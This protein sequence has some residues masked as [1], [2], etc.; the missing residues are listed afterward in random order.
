MSVTYKATAL[1]GIVNIPVGGY[2]EH[3][4]LNIYGNNDYLPLVVNGAL[5]H[6]SIKSIVFILVR[7]F[8]H[9]N[10]IKYFW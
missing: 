2:N 8:N 4:L 6:A 9:T 3:I 1:E 5:H 7:S 10:F